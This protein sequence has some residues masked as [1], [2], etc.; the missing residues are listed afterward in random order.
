MK[1]ETLNLFDRMDQG[2]V[3]ISEVDKSTT[4]ASAPAVQILEQ[5]PHDDF[6]NN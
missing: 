4:L 5:Q 1:E 6:K 2:L 3:V